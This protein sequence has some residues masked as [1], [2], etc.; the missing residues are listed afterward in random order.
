MRG[1]QHLRCQ[2]NG[3]IQSYVNENGRLGDG[4]RCHYGARQPG[5]ESRANQETS[6]SRGRPGCRRRLGLE[7]VLVLVAGRSGCSCE[8]PIPLLGRRQLSE[9]PLIQWPNLTPPFVL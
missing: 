5:K 4:W 8:L 6:Q 2:A 9:R 7:S 3:T 1:G